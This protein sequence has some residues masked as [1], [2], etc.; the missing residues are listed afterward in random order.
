[1][2]IP[3]ILLS[4]G[5]LMGCGNRISSENQ[6]L[7][8]Q[9]NRKITLID[10]NHRVQIVEDDFHSGDSIFKIRGYF[11]DDELVKLVSVLNTPDMER[12]DYFYFDDNVTIFA[13][14]LFNQ[15]N[16][17]HASEY[18]FY[19][20]KGQIVQAYFWEDDYKRGQRFPH[21]NF[22]IFEP[23]MD[24]LNRSEKQRFE[25][26]ISKLEMEGFEILHLNENLDAN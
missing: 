25:Y 16:K 21:E 2:K 19:Y 10:Q 6:A 5:L 8:D 3:V 12:D 7:I 24:S 13:G 23:N 26:F 14:H 22:E 20:N 18:K 17:L 11:M 15:R 9:T 4:I 1:M